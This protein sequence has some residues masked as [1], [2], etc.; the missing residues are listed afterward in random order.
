MMVATSGALDQEEINSVRRWAPN[1]SAIP[2]FKS[3]P[4]KYNGIEIFEFSEGYAFKVSVS[5]G[6]SLVAVLMSLLEEPL[7]A[8][9]F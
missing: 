4:Q 9:S 2:A 7:P 5:V 3:S 6:G 1:C 8:Y